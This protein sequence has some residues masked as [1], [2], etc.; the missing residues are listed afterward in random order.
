MIWVVLASFVV[1]G[2]QAQDQGSPTCGMYNGTICAGKVRWTVLLEQAAL[3]E[4]YVARQFSTDSFKTLKA[5]DPK[6][7]DAWQ[8]WV[9]TNYFQDCGN[10]VM[11]DEALNSLIRVLGPVRVIST[12]F[13]LAVFL[14][15]LLLPDKRTHPRVMVLYV[16]FCVLAFQ[17]IS[18]FPSIGDR[19]ELSCAYS[20]HDAVGAVASASQSTNI[21]CAI[22]GSMYIF[23]SLSL[24]LWI[25]MLILNMHLQTVWGSSILEKHYSIIHLFCWGIPAIFMITALITGSVRASHGFHCLVGPGLSD[26]FVFYPAAAII[27]PTIIIHLCTSSWIAWA[28]RKQDDEDSKHETLDLVAFPVSPGIDAPRPSFTSHRSSTQATGGLQ[29]STFSLSRSTQLSPSYLQQKP[30]G[31]AT[32]ATA[33]R[34]GSMDGVRPSMDG[35]V[36]SAHDLDAR[37]LASQSLQTALAPAQNE[38]EIVGIFSVQGRIILMAL[39]VTFVLLGVWTF[40]DIDIPQLL[41][42]I[43]LQPLFTQT[44]F[45]T[46]LTCIVETNG[47]QNACHQRIQ[48]SI[49]H[50]ARLVAMESLVSLAGAMCFAVFFANT[51]LY[52]EWKTFLSIKKRRSGSRR[53]WVR[54]REQKSNE[55]GGSGV[56]PMSDLRMRTSRADSGSRSD[57]TVYPP[58]KAHR[59]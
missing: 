34:L 54:R 4:S 33:Y 24:L 55:D 49:P 30:L 18:I 27:M 3:A 53:G 42:I 29:G 17:V 10:S 22:Q 32:G 46:W 59:M 11:V 35:Y 26:S 37:S 2:V 12:L 48:N 57:D 7:A 13:G 50:Y 6:C 51:T 25:L 21:A 41:N 56:Y 1:G 23:F 43:H 20:G 19:K 40:H 9:C 36:H 15:Y 8:R 5:F 39:S 45:E 38:I 52:S 31:V 58:S 28:S 44:T 16:S 47:D 14:S